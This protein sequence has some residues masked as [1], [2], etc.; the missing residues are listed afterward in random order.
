VVV[1]NAVFGTLIGAAAGIFP[2]ARQ[3]G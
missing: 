1:I 3:W 2:L